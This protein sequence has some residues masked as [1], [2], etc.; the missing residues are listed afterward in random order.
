MK[1][2]D[3]CVHVVEVIMHGRPEAT[4]VGV[5]T[6]C[7]ALCSSLPSGKHYPQQFNGFWLF[8]LHATGHSLQVCNIIITSPQGGISA[9]TGSIHTNPKYF[10]LSCSGKVTHYLSL[11]FAPLLGYIYALANL[12]SRNQCL[13]PV[14]TTLFTVLH[15]SSQAWH[16]SEWTVGWNILL[17]PIFF[18]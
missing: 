18:S 2:H 15:I 7:V 13:P 6:L 10:K 11:P 3:F 12:Q 17:V 5:H 16:L 9:T 1:M 14:C 8:T 4:L